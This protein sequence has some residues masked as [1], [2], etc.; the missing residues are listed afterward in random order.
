MNV[1][2]GTIHWFLGMNLAKEID[3]KPGTA[4]AERLE[5]CSGIVVDEAFTKNH[6]VWDVFLGACRDFP[7][8]PEFRKSNSLAAYGHRDILLLADHW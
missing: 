5:A 3:I 1:G 2:G 4:L 7:L 8:K 6:E